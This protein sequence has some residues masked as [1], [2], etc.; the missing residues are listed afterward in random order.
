M[1]R[2]LSQNGVQQASRRVGSLDGLRAVA[3]VAIVALHRWPLALPGG[4][5]GVDLF[6]VLSGFLIT[7]LLQ[8]ELSDR[9]TIDVAGYIARRALRIV[10]ALFAMLLVHSAYAWFARRDP[11]HDVTVAIMAMS[12]VTNWVR[13]FSSFAEGPLGHT[14]SLSTEEQFYLLW[15]F[16]LMAMGVRHRARWTLALLLGVVCWRAA[17]ALGGADAERTYNGFDTH[18]DGILLGCLLALAPLPRGLSVW[19]AQWVVL[20]LAFLTAVLIAVGYRSVPVQ[21]FG[22]FAVALA[23]AWLVVAAM[24]GG[25]FARVLA[26]PPFRYTGRISY[27]L[28]LWHL[29]ILAHGPRYVP[30]DWVGTTVLFVVIYATGALSHHLIERPFMALRDRLPATA[31]RRPAIAVG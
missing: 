19:A 24:E 8:R 31:V 26:W 22:M 17:L 27:S 5:A 16:L 10:P 6:F 4:W 21:A 20:P 1:D 9:G 12:F 3:I 7:G 29:P 18:S 11:H 2:G 30:H 23:A 25:N 28:Y 15:P 14:W 13:A